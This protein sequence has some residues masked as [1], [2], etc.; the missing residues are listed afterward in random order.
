MHY[1][2]EESKELA[3]FLKESG[4]ESVNPVEKLTL[5]KKDIEGKKGEV[6]VLQIS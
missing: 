6:V 1:G 4:E 3:Q 2:K 5:K